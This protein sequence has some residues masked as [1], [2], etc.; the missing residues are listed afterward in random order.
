MEA[1]NVKAVHEALVQCEL[2]LGNVSRHGHQTLN[3]GDKCTACDSVDELRGM[4]VR[5]LADQPRNCDI[6][7]TVEQ[8]KRFKKF[9]FDN[10]GDGM[11]KDRCSKCPLYKTKSSCWLDWAQIPYESQNG[12]D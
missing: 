9:C 4:V 12:K 7:T 10:M 5:A 1:S 2:F 11:N 8:Y 6:G 3:P